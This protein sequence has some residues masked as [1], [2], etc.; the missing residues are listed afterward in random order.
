MFDLQITFAEITHQRHLYVYFQ[1]SGID[2][3][4]KVTFSSNFFG[5]FSIS[6][7][8]IAPN[9]IDFDALFADFA[10]NLKDSPYVLALNLFLLAFTLIG[11]LLIR[12]KDKADYDN[13]SRVYTK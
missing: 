13:V 10:D 8:V 5:T 12:R 6:S 3:E 7:M 11:A 4:G 9:T 1:I 2:E